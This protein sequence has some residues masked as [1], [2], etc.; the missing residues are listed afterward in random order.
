M[1]F[2]HGKSEEKIPA[3]DGRGS[4]ERFYEKKN[5]RAPEGL[6]VFNYRR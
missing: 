4:S 5:R 6:P 1:I 2:R 3:I